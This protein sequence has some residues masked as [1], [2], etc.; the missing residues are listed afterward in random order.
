[1]ADTDQNT[2]PQPPRQ[3]ATQEMLDTAS[4]FITEIRTRDAQLADYITNSR[5][6]NADPLR[7]NQATFQHS[8]A[9]ATES[10][11]KALGHQLPLSEGARSDMTRRPPPT[12]GC[13]QQSRVGPQHSH[14]S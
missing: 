6:E 4:R 11:E 1:M 13:H 8:V 14:H 10:A 12:N 2:A 9:Y 3:P 5:A 7:A